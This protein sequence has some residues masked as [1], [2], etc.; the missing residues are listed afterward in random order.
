MSRWFLQKI[1]LRVLC[2]SFLK[3]YSFALSSYVYI[4]KL[5]HLLKIPDK[6]WEKFVS[7]TMSRLRSGM[8]K[9]Q[10]A[11]SLAVTEETIQCSS[12]C[13]GN[14]NLLQCTRD[15]NAWDFVLGISWR[16]STHG[17]F[18]MEN[19]P[20]KIQ[21]AFLSLEIILPSSSF[22]ATTPEDT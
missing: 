8:K 13:S 18:A 3:K 10:M 5:D 16:N 12:M 19:L 15:V 4:H 2:V 9:E 17:K 6:S 7:V 14:M 20:W 22:T 21:A 1:R 11:H